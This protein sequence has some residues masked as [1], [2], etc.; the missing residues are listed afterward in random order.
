LTVFLIEVYG[1]NAGFILQFL[2]TTMETKNVAEQRPNHHW[3]PALAAGIAT[4]LAAGLFI[5]SK[6]GQRMTEDAKKMAAQMQKQLMKKMEQ[7]KDLTQEKYQELVDDIVERYQGTKD[8][9]ASEIED[10]KMYLLDQWDDIR[11]Q[12]K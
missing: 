10:L 1:R 2:H 12:L 8:L 5:R 4:G 6:N 3:A 11:S 7:V 9:A